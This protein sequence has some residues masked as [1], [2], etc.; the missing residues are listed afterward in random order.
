M[1]VSMVS[2]VVLMLAIVL[3]V[4]YLASAVTAVSVDDEAVRV[5]DPLRID[6]RKIQSFQILLGQ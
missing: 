2:L 1:A 6:R 5:L 3:Q 4:A